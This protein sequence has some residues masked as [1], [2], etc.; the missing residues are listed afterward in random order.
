MAF[1]LLGVAGTV[2]APADAGFAAPGAELAA[3][4]TGDE[5]AILASSV[6][7][8]LAGAAL[9]VFC[10]FLRGAVAS[11]RLS[12]VVFAGGIA[13]AALALG[14]AAINAGAALRVMER[15][16]IDPAVA[17]AAWDASNMLYGLAAPIALGTLTLAFALSG[18]LPRW[19]AAISLLLGIAL[20][21]PP[22]N[23]IAVIVFGFWCLVTG[24]LLFG[25]RV[26][27]LERDL[28]A[29]AA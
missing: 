21:L 18:T 20:L 9:I 25:L 10:A 11:P 13:G 2:I 6:A 27:A 17:S 19:H 28:S 24:G 23:Y 3:Y 7:Y 5:A 12:A 4:Y 22:I 8:L 26:P 16:A 29:S 1:C 14:G 15:D